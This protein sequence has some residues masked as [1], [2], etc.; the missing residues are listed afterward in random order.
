M[1]RRFAGGH[2]RRWI[3]R[4]GLAISPFLPIAAALAAEAPAE[5]VALDEG[6]RVA[7]YEIAFDEIFLLDG[8]GGSLRPRLSSL[9]TPVRS[10]AELNEHLRRLQREKSQ[11]AEVVVYEAGQPRSEAT[12]R[13][14]SPKARVEFSRPELADPTVR[15]LG[16]AGWQRTG[17]P[18]H[19]IVTAANAAELLL[20]LDALR[21]HRNVVAAEPLVRLRMKKDLIPSDFYFDRQWNLLATSPGDVDINVTPAWDQTL[22]RGVVIGISDDGV[23]LLHPDL[24]ANARADLSYDFVRDAPHSDF[25]LETDDYHGTLVAGAAAARGNN[26]F[27]VAGVAFQS[28]LASLRILSGAGETDDVVA[29]SMAHRP[30]DIRVVNCSWG[31]EGWFAGPGTLTRVAIKQLAEAGRIFVFAAG[32]D[33]AEGRMSNYTGHANSPYTIAVG[34]VTRAG[35]RAIYSE[36][37]ANLIVAAPAGVITT[38]RTGEIGKNPGT[39]PGGLPDAYFEPFGGTSAAAPQVSGVVA[40]MLAVNSRLSWRDVQE[41]LIRTARPNTLPGWVTNAAAL[42]FHLDYGAGLV[43]ADAAVRTARTWRRLGKQTM[44]TVSS[45]PMAT[46]PDADLA[47]RVETLTQSA[48]GRVEHVEVTV[49]LTHPR[50]SDLEID[51]ISPSGTVSPLLERGATWSAGTLRWTFMTVWNWGEPAKGDWKVAVRD[52]TAGNEGVLRSVTVNVYMGPDGGVSPPPEFSGDLRHPTRD[53]LAPEPRNPDPEVRT[54]DTATRSPTR[55]AGG[56]GI[57]S[58]TRDPENPGIRSPTRRP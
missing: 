21:R 26:G 48:R 16:L 49:D 47:G 19:F 24:T 53:P 13:I 43:D 33:G 18:A 44:V 41:I 51:V 5:R 46:V 30:S 56:G 15:E 12:R 29:R 6:S 52:V 34:A 55:T 23:Q 2:W 27:G 3:R 4:L 54:P 57:R 50:L 42:K 45:A 38:D 35:A 25:A 14:I 17:S 58:P 20:K 31:P 1:K 9:V 11:K 40:L 28:S 39:D 8:T 7:T 32:N 37:G 10:L 22:G 36:R